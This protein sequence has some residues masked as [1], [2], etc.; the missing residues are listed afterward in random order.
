MHERL[1]DTRMNGWIWMLLIL[2]G[3]LLAAMC[4]N[5]GVRM[6]DGFIKKDTKLRRFIHSSNLHC[7]DGILTQADNVQQQDVSCLRLVQQRWHLHQGPLPSLQ[8]AETPRSW[9]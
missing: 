5:E 9:W 4:K 1:I 2:V 7:L 3:I 8:C 6:K